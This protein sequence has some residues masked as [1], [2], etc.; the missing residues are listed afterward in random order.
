[1]AITEKT[2]IWCR[3]HDWGTDARLENGKVVGLV[4]RFTI[5]G[6]LFERPV[7]FTDRAEL[8]AWAGY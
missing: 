2:I 5:D 6:R 7:E 4:D 3:S 8:R 1:M